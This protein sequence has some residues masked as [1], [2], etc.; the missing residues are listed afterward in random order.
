[1]PN[2]VGKAEQSAEHL[3]KMIGEV[4]GEDAAKVTKWISEN[5]KISAT[6]V[7]L[8][9]KSGG[10]RA[11]AII[12]ETNKRDAVR[13]F[14]SK[15]LVDEYVWSKNQK[16]TTTPSSKNV[17]DRIMLEK[18]QGISK[19]RSYQFDKFNGQNKE[20]LKALNNVG[21]RGEILNGMIFKDRKK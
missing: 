20:D 17:L 16:A 11:L 7:D 12:N 2:I 19:D 13:T 14:D 8:M 1:M 10:R 21:T 15:K 9:S 4:V 6:S 3:I 5:G 18:R